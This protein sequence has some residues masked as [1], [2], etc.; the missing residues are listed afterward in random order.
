MAISLVAQS[1]AEP[2]AWWKPPIEAERKRVSK[3]AGSVAGS[4][5]GIIVSTSKVKALYFS[6]FSAPDPEMKDSELFTDDV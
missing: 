3:K 1:Y 2:V 4:F 5:S 6:N